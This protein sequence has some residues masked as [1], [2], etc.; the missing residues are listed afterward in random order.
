MVSRKDS[1]IKP[2]QKQLDGDT[3]TDGEHIA[4]IPKTYLKAPIMIEGPD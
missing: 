2:K 4:P 3:P 1:F